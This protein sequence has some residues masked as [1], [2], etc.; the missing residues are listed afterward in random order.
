VP[1]NIIGERV[2]GSEEPND[3]KVSPFSELPRNN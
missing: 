3:D 2:S 1:R